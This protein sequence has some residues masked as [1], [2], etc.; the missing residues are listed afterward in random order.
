M[1]STKSLI[2]AIKRKKDAISKHR[3][4]LR[5]LSGEIDSMIRDCILDATR[6]R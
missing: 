5:K 2:A 6:G 4:A 1:K 3:D